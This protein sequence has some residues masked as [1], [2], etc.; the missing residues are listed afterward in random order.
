MDAGRAVIECENTVGRV[1][2]AGCVAVERCITVGHVVVASCG[3]SERGK[4][5]GRVV[6]AGGEAEK[7]TI[8]LSGVAVGIASVRCRGNPESFRGRRKRKAAERQRDEKETAPPR[9][10]A[11]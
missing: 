10:A 6:C 7:R 9:P 1:V 8:A 4:T 5:I 3:G 2:I 11:N